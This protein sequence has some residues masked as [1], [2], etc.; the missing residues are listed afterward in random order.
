MPDQRKAGTS[1]IAV[2]RAVNV[3][4]HANVAMAELRA[5]VTKLGF[6]DARSIVQSGNLIFGADPRDGGEL[7]RLLENE[8][9]KRLGL[10]TDIM[11]RSGEEWIDLVGRN[12]FP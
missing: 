11:V 6:R 12:P 3:A 8:A 4:G 9:E 7:E 2:L 5:L 10:R 1:Y